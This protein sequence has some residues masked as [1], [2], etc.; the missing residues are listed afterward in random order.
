MPCPLGLRIET[1]LSFF[2]DQRDGLLVYA[3]VF[4]LIFLVA[5]KEIRGAIRDFHPAGRDVR[6]LHLLH[7]FTTSRGGYSP[8]ARPTLF[9]MWIMVLALYAYYQ[10]TGETGKTLFRFLAGLT[11]FATAWL[12]Y[13]PLFL[14]Q[15]VTR[16]VS[17]RASS[18]LVF[19]SSS[20]VDLSTFF[21]SFLKKPNNGYLPNWLW[22]SALAVALG[23]Y[24]ARA[25][26]RPLAR[27]ARVVLPVLGLLLMVPV[28]FS[29]TF[30][31]RRAILRRGSRS[32][33]IPGIS[34]GTRKPE[35]SGSRPGRIMT[36]S[37]TWTAA[38]PTGWT[39]AC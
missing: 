13:Y 27:P 5:K 30:T 25:S 2:L 26:W 36:C 11:V 35:A 28:C 37:S 23:L 22:L 12:F 14:Y 4:L 18:L 29:P 17:Q 6:F 31:C 32:T 8:A 16:E 10:R 19:L 9:V 33:A 15:P 21:P 20:A 3:P 34:P 1:L 7:A 38:P 24:Y 39:C